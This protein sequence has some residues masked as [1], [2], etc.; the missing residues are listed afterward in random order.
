MNTQIN[1]ELETPNARPVKTESRRKLGKGAWLAIAMIVAVTPFFIYS[2]ATRP[3]P[4]PVHLAPTPPLFPGHPVA[5][6]AADIAL[7]ILGFV[8]SVL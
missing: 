5:S 7:D 2:M 3:A 1:S 4:P 6:K 8:L